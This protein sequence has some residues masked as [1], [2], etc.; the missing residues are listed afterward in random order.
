[1][2]LISSLFG[3]D[4]RQPSETDDDLRR[5]AQNIIGNGQSRLCL[6]DSAE[7][8]SADTVEQLRKYLGKI[9]GRVQD[10]GRKDARLAFVAA[11]RRDNGWQGITPFPRTVLLAAGRDRAKRRKG[12]TRRASARHPGSA[13]TRGTTEG[14]RLVHRV[15]EGMP[16]LVMKS[17][18]W[19]QA[20]QWLDIE[21][22]DRPPFFGEIVEPYVWVDCWPGKPP[23]RQKTA[24][25]RSRRSS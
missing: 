22:L 25:P 8:L 21:R 10:S 19:I 9:H 15:T 12:R 3:L 23:A 14:C 2:T 13:L 24:S 18:Q 16:E 11:S 6:L 5:T 1:M 17:L 4:P 7:L 20:E